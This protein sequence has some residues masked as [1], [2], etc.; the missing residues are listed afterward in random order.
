MVE[1]SLKVKRTDGNTSEEDEELIDG[2]FEFQQSPLC[3][4]M[5]LQNVRLFGPQGPIDVRFA[6]LKCA[7]EATI[8]V[9]VKRATAGYKL[10]TVTASTCGYSD[11]IKLYDSLTASP[12]A[13]MEEGG[14]SSSMVAVASAVVAVEL[15]CELKLRIEI[16]TSEDERALGGHVR[17]DS[18]E[19]LFRSQ[20]HHS[21]KGS[22]I[23]GKMITVDVKVTWSTMGK[24]YLPIFPSNWSLLGEK[25][26]GPCS[27]RDR[28]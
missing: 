6:L 14:S 3:G 22:I 5:Q 9:T 20:K 11:Q 26:G 19:L 13:E 7:V 28:S 4:D 18:H 8:D 15:G 16:A 17:K 12:V 2:C 10:S 1:Y 27:H 25:P 24:H 23:L 21:S